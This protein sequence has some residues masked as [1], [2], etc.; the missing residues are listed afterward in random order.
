M[1]RGHSCWDFLTKCDHRVVKYFL[2]I[3]V[4]CEEFDTKA[5]PL[6]DGVVMEKEGYRPIY[7]SRRIFS[8]K[9]DT[10]KF[11]DGLARKEALCSAKGTWTLLPGSCQGFHSIWV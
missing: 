3:D 2:Q 7:D 11:S 10:A 9:S 4:T 5:N 6:P 1:W 8:C